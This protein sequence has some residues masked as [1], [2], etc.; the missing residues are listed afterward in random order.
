MGITLEL[1][2]LE[3]E[4]LRGCLRFYRD[5]ATHD[6]KEHCGLEASDPEWKPI[7]DIMQKLHDKNR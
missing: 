3:C 6:G 5:D 4:V 1:T 7:T 2:D